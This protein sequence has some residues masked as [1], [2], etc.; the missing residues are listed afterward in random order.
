MRVEV[1][2]SSHEPAVGVFTTAG[3]CQ[4]RLRWGSVRH[5]P[6]LEAASFIARDGTSISSWGN[7]PHAVVFPDEWRGAMPVRIENPYGISL[8]H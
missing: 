2:V 4:G 3:T 1:W 7:Q 5:P 8:G 6:R